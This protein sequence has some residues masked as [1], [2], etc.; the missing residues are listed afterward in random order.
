MP[1]D[2]PHPIMPRP[3]ARPLGVPTI[4]P[5]PTSGDR[6]IPAAVVR[7]LQAA[8]AKTL[9]LGQKGVRVEEGYWMGPGAD[10]VPVNMT[11]NNDRP[12][13]IDPTDESIPN[14]DGLP[15]IPVA[16]N[17]NY[18]PW[19]NPTYRSLPLSPSMEGCI[20]WYEIPTQLPTVQVPHGYFFVIKGISYVALNGVQDDVIDFQ[21]LVSGAL[22]AHWE[23]AI[24]DAA[25]ASPAN[26]YALAGTAHDMPLNIIADHDT[27]ITVLATLRGPLNLAG[28][29][30]NFPGQPITTGNCLVRVILNG[31]AV[32]MREQTDSGSRPTD[33]GDFGNLPLTDDQG[34]YQV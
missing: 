5:L 24:A 23:D 2:L 33:L 13:I 25:Q 19:N 27:V 34:G 3:G 22:A 7:Q 9:P 32:P 8:Q 26:R 1:D 10:A 21:L 20:P 31:W 17:L 15:K 28:V 11:M 30:P 6:R 29:D 14:S 18:P 4:V 16:L 12:I